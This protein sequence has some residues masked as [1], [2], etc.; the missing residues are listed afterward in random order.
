MDKRRLAVIGFSTECNSFSPPLRLNDFQQLCYLQGEEI[1]KASSL[2]ALPGEVQ[3]FIEAA[4]ARNDVSL[5]PILVAFSEAG[6]PLTDE[7][8]AIIS[9]E[10]EQRLRQ[11]GPLDGIYCALH[12]AMMTES[13]YDVEGELLSRIKQ[14]C[15]QDIPV[16]ST[17]DLHGKVTLRM[18]QL[19]TLLAYKTNPHVDQKICGEKAAQLLCAQINGE[20]VLS[21]L[22]HVPVI[23]TSSSTISGFYADLMRDSRELEK[24]DILDISLL[25]GFSKSDHPYNVFS[26]IVTHKNNAKQAA[27]IVLALV[28]LVW[29]SRAALQENALPLPDAIKR[30]RQLLA[31]GSGKAVCLADTADNPGGGGGGNTLYALRSLVDSS[32]HKTLLG[33]L[34]DSDAVQQAIRIG[35]GQAGRIVF[36]RHPADQYAETAAFDVKVIRL[37]DGICIGRRGTIAGRKI[38]HGPSA[39]VRVGDVDVAIISHRYQTLD[40]AQLE[41]YG[42]NIRDYCLLVLK[43]RA[44][45]QAGFD[46]FFAPDRI[47][48]FD[49]PGLT[50]VNLA[51]FNFKNLRRPIYPLDPHMAWA[52]KPEDVLWGQ[53]SVH[54]SH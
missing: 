48:L 21:C 18:L 8:F 23:S 50:S 12:G 10:I 1:L 27:D 39:L 33:S 47:I 24:D 26:I 37:V 54:S 32:I 13:S 41:M 7:C 46:E 15:G 20:K 2:G 29:S 45:F 3:G 11:A 14:I 17:L 44:H 42:I 4:H 30:A 22:L 28:Q 31:D 38:Q 40:P 43:S 53:E 9:A 36:N 16:V 19:S 51:H 49:A 6:G 52:A 5:A 34:C 25:P 35:A